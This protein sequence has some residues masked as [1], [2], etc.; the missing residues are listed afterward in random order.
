MYRFLITVFISI[1]LGSAAIAQSTDPGAKAGEAIT[2]SANTAPKNYTYEGLLALGHGKY[3]AQDYTAAM[4]A[5]EQA[6]TREPA[7]ADAYYFIGMTLRAQGDYQKAVSMLTSAATVAGEDAPKMN[8][9]ALFVIASTWELAHNL[10]KAKYAWI[11]Y[12]A[13]A[14]LHPECNPFI[15]VAD[16]HVNAIDNRNRQVSDYAKVNERIAANAEG[17]D[18]SKKKE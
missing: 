9:R 12:K 10:D 13:F 18:N 4:E 7:K 6:R 2:D 17:S 15:Q 1:A 5:Y 14:K 16:A 8:A 3:V 11:Q